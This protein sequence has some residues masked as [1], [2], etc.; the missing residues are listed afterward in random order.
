MCFFI[1]LLLYQQQP[2]LLKQGEERQKGEGKKDG[3]WGMRD[4][5]GFLRSPLSFSRS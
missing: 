1:T 3:G 5:K 2:N 4:E